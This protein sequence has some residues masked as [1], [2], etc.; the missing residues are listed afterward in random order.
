MGEVQDVITQKTIQM[1]EFAIQKSVPTIFD[2]MKA[3]CLWLIKNANQPKRGQQSLKSLEK[4][5]GA[6]ESIPL[7]SDSIKAFKGIARKYGVDF[8]LSSGNTKNPSQHMVY[9]KAK[10][11]ETMSAAFREFFTSEIR[12]GKPDKATL[13]ERLNAAKS[14]VKVQEK[15]K[16]QQREV[17]GR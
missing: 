6:L 11:I 14:R 13:K 3:I 9:F 5:G 10:D 17:E 12:K 16:N 7:N 8:A 1:T 2:V 15:I 4:Y